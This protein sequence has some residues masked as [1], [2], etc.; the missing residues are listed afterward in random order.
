MMQKALRV[1]LSAALALTFARSADAHIVASRLGDFYA[2]AL[3]PLTDL[4]DVVLWIAVGLLAASVAPAQGRWLVPVVPAG[5]LAGLITGL[6]FNITSLSTVANAGLMIALGLLIA[7]AVR[8][9]ALVIGVLAFGMTWMRGIVNAGGVA[10]DTNQPLF[11]AG[12]TVAAYAV[13]TLLMAIT[14]TFR[15][16]TAAN[17]VGAWRGIAIRVCGSWIAAIGLMMGAFALAGR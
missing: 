12:F 13:V 2:G 1:A 9:P 10:A 8:I 16:P 5:S 14:V 3:H 17:G 4:Q 6:V 11:A 7:T 15:A